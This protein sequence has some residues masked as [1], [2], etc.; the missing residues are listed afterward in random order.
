MP[1]KSYY[2]RMKSEHRCVQCGAQLRG[3]RRDKTTCKKCADKHKTYSADKYKRDKEYC[4]EHGICPRCGI[5]KL[6]GDEK[7]C[8]ECSAK[9]YTYGIKYRQDNPEYSERKNLK[10]KNQRDYRRENKLCTICGTPLSD[11]KYLN[12]E[13]CRR[14][15]ALISQKHRAN[16]ALTK[17]MVISKQDRIQMRICVFCDEPVEEG[18]KV[19]KKHHEMLIENSKK[20]D[21][22]NFKSM[23]YRMRCK[24][25]V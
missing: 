19:C 21:R 3:T 4:S 14:K 5:N 1:V 16:V 13:S 7:N 2:N 10:A 12:C 11:F 23:N 18:Y 6:F 20:T 17:P 22:S 8:L 15:R 25:G 24:D 9:Q